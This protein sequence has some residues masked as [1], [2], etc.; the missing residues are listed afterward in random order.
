MGASWVRAAL[1]F[2]CLDGESQWEHIPEA[3][4]LEAKHAVWAFFH[5]WEAGPCTARKLV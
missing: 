4:I 1:L 2:R 5:I 3:L